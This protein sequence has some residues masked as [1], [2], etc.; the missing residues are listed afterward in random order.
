V[1]G[2]QTGGDIGGLAA[3]VALG[4]PT[5]GWAPKGWRTDDG[6]APWLAQFGVRE[7]A[8]YSYP[9]RTVQN[10]RD[11]DGT[12]WVGNPGS[13]GGKLTL[14][15]TR[16]LGKPSFVVLRNVPL[17]DKVTQRAFR[18]WIA[19]FQIKVLNVA[20]NRES[21]SPGIGE[22]TRDFLVLSLRG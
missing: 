14:R 8:S 5:G 6:P 18:E 16:E 1:S 22:F 20:G 21:S 11:S 17:T 7:H 4:I 9:P 10:V 12:L 19:L 15:T 2:G 3:G 13:P